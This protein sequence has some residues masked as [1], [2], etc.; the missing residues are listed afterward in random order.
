M[1]AALYLRTGRMADPDKGQ[2]TE[3]QLIGPRPPLK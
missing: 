3:N 1:K 2:T